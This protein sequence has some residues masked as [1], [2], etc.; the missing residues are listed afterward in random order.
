MVCATGPRMPRAARR[1]LGVT[2]A[3][4]ALSGCASSGT[5]A[6][7]LSLPGTPVAPVTLRYSTDKSGWSGGLSLT[8]PRGGTFSGRY[9]RVEA[10]AHVTPF[11][12]DTAALL[13]F[14]ESRWAL[15]ANRWTFDEE[16]P[17][18]VLATL[19]DD[20]GDTMHCRFELLYAAGELRDGATG[21]CVGSSGERIR[22][23][24]SPSPSRDTKARA[25]ESP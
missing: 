15:A 20:L 21:E 4:V 25:P 2:L 16:R 6:G 19:A 9:V 1:A 3:A 5:I 23:N 14:S 22:L 11:P 8:L 7:W 24:F 17:D 10:P 12:D 13:D 18:T